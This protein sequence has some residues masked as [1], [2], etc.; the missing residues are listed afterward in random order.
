MV[1]ICAMQL[2]HYPLDSQWCN[3][4][5]LSYAYDV[6]QLIIRW[7]DVDPITRNPNITLPDMQIAR[8]EPGICDGNYST[9]VWSCVTAEFFV[10]RSG[11]L[12]SSSCCKL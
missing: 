6:D 9:G 11:S 10:S 7:L 8:L 1:V 5:M 12:K 2:H 4:R 3:L